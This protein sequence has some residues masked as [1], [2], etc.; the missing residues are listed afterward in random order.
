MTR[1]T[2]VLMALIVALV[3]AAVLSA[4]SGNG[5]R[6]TSVLA[7]SDPSQLALPAS[8]LPSTTILPLDHSAVSDNKDADGN[9]SCVAN[10]DGSVAQMKCGHPGYNYE[11]FNRVT[12]YREDFRYTLTASSVGTQQ[13]GTEYLASVM[14]D[15][16]SA[17]KAFNAFTGPTSLISYIAIENVPCSIGDQCAFFVGPNPGTPNLAVYAVFTRGPILIETASQVPAGDNDTTFKALEPAMKTTLFS[18]LEA[19]DV[20]A[21]LYLNQATDTPV[22]GSTSATSTSIPAPP[23]ATVAPTSTPVPTATPKPKSKKPKCK[24]GY[25]AVK[26]SG[27]WKC[28]KKKK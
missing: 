25:T 21:E 14:P 17:T 3:V 7:A 4:G 8:A 10:P 24:K 5:A 11:D 19:A 2:P 22:T 6:T 27:K 20:Q 9:G 26:K 18:L 16:A 12:G 15:V 23:T 13:V 28:V 1:R